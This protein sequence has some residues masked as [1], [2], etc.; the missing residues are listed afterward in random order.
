MKTIELTKP[1]LGLIALTRAM[2]G[3]GIGLL[4]A[5]KLSTEQQAAV[6]WTLT[7]VGVVTTIP[8]AMEVLKCDGMCGTENGK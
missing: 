8:L 5:R 7:G 2:L 1:Q 3:M 6:G 4:I